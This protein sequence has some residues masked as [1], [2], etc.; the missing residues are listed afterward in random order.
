MFSYRKAALFS[1]AF[2][3]VLQ[4]MI[5]LSRNACA[6]AVSSISACARVLGSLAVWA[7]LGGCSVQPWLSPQEKAE[8]IAKAAGF[9]L[10]KVASSPFLLTT[11]QTANPLGNDTLTVY[12]EGD[13]APWISPTHPPRDPTPLNPVSLILAS[14]DQ[15]HPIL[16]IA[17]PCQ[18]LNETE[19][20]SC[21]YKNWTTGRFS[22]EAI[23][24][25]DNVV[26]AVTASTGVRRVRL[27]GFSGGGVVAALVAARRQDV[28]SLVTVAAPLDVAA[29]SAFHKIDP[30]RDSLNPMDF[31]RELSQI[32]QVHWV[33]EKD[34]IVPPAYAKA[35]QTKMPFAKYIIVPGY[36]HQCCWIENWPEL[37]SKELR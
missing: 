16:Y 28:D 1:A 9:E 33:G 25:A 26:S 29:W 27:V 23:E 2:L 11:F 8:S 17:R 13:G 30:L 36:T 35:V 5:S 14:R 4:A 37:I 20:A 19:L 32:R 22:P 24:A 10:K 6:A 34:T 3:L 18:Y 15:R 31:I 12:I 7:A 21:Y